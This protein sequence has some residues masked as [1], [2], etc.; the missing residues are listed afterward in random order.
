MENIIKLV[1]YADYVYYDKQNTNTAH[2]GVNLAETKK[3]YFLSTLWFKK[4]IIAVFQ[5]LPEDAPLHRV[6]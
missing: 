4:L 5:N 1:G 6:R 2:T 3:Y